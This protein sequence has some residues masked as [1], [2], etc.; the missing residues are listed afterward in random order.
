MS[1]IHQIK[2]EDLY[3]V[4]LLIYSDTD[5]CGYSLVGRHVRPHV[6]DTDTLL[7]YELVQSVVD[8]LQEGRETIN[9]STYQQLKIDWVT[10]PPPISQNKWDYEIVDDCLY[11]PM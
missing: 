7:E 1:R 2:L 11:S 5:G 4:P 3:D 8:F 6:W 10:C 9:E